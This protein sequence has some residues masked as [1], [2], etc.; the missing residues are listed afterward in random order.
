MSELPLNPAASGDASQGD[1]QAAS[2]AVAETENTMVR[3]AAR[4]LAQGWFSIPIPKG[5]K[6]P[7]LRGWQKLRL[8]ETDLPRHFDDG[9]PSIGLLLGEPSGGLVDVDLDAREAVQAAPTFL[10][11]TERIHGRPGK[12]DSHW[13]YIADPVPR[14]VKFKDTDQSMLCELRSTG[15]QTVVPP[16]IHPSGEQ[17]SWRAEGEPARIASDV[18]RAR[19]AR[20]AACAL[21][22]RHWPA[23]G[24]RH[25]A[26][27]AAA[28]LLLR[29]GLAGSFTSCMA[30]NTQTWVSY[31]GLPLCR[32][33]AERQG[34]SLLAYRD[35]LKT[36]WHL[37]ARGGAADAAACREALDVVRR[38]VDVVGEPVAS[39]LRQRWEQA[40]QLETGQC[41]RCGDTHAEEPG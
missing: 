6:A 14:T 40:W 26:A 12:P 11:S 23:R 24:S 39:R 20:V 38:L 3:V 8:T 28:G 16:S 5:E 10:P 21:L 4:Y 30:C 7:L 17:L 27:L 9:S 15:Q 22:A 33:C 1:P 35:A 32:L 18:L 37:V 34:A 36:A 25:E 41:P 19:V 29:G 31:G 2:G 13:W